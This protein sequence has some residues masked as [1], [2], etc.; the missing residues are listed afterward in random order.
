MTWV[1]LTKD[2]LFLMQSNNNCFLEK[3]DI[4]PSSNGQLT[5]DVPRDWFHEDGA[6]GTMIV[7]I[8]GSTDGAC[9]M[10]APGRLLLKRGTV[11]TEDLLQPNI[12]DIALLNSYLRSR[13]PGDSPLKSE[14]RQEL[15]RGIT[16]A[17]MKHGI[18]PM[19]ILALAI[20]ESGWGR[21]AIARLKNNLFGYGAFDSDPFNA[22]WTFKDYEDCCDQVMQK[23]KA[24]YLVPAGAFF[25]GA[26]LK[27]MNVKY[28]T[29]RGVNGW[30][31]KLRS[32]MNSM[33]DYANENSI[34]ELSGSIVINSGTPLPPLPILDR[35][36]QRNMI[37]D[38][39]EAVQRFFQAL[40]Y[41][42]G[43]T[44]GDFGPLTEEAVRRFQ[45]QAGI[46][47]DGVVGPQTIQVLRQ[48]AENRPDDGGIIADPARFIGGTSAERRTKLAEIA[49]E[50]AKRE[51]V[52]RST[53]SEAEKFLRILRPS[54]GVPSGRYEWCGAF[55]LWCCRQ[56]GFPLPEK[57]EGFWATFALVESWYEWASKKGFWYERNKIAPTAGDIVLF[58]WTGDPYRFNHIGIVTEYTPGSGRIISAD[59]NSPVDQTGIRN[60]PTNLVAGYI[61]IEM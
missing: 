24:A 28:S 43:T 45:L 56:A 33:V 4:K 29:D 60:R 23:V 50:Q 15:L 13:S 22:A 35:D 42:T 55:V 41:D 37:G 49:K 57:P 18:N 3:V 47:V 7:D 36:L 21:S 51:L 59:G 1:K 6:P 8:N 5:L 20:L 38:D 12:V 53:N 48:A 34:I 16:T 26:T 31:Y 10:P 44:D 40:G 32:L 11:D 25:N 2:G 58:D 27:G 30:A 46:E 52:W 17:S 19:F 9:P 39:V 14:K 61:R 54:L